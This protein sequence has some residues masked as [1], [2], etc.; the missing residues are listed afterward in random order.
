MNLE[1]KKCWH[2]EK[3]LPA[4]EIKKDICKPC[5]ALYRKTRYFL[6]KPQIKRK[7]NK[8]CNLNFTLMSNLPLGAWKVIHSQSR[9]EI[10]YIILSE[11]YVITKLMY[12]DA[13]KTFPDFVGLGL[14]LANQGLLI[15]SPYKEPIN[16]SELANLEYS[17][18]DAL[19]SKTAERLRLETLNLMKSEILQEIKSKDPKLFKDVKVLATKKL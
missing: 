13:V 1:T 12:R 5:Q 6:A 19:L 14:Y 10:G 11:T 7:S 8:L 18:I 9:K 4:V 15:E 3:H 2:C 17:P 16:D